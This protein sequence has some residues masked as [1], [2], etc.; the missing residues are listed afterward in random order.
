MN[1]GTILK[2]QSPQQLTAEYAYVAL[3]III[4]SIH[5]PVAPFPA[6]R[7]QKYDDGRHWK[8]KRERKAVPNSSVTTRTNKM[9]YL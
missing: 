8:M 4:L 3:T 9:V 7:F 6:N 2:I 5:F 1:I